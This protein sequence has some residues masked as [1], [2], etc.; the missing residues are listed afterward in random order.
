MTDDAHLV[1]KMMDA[2]S[3]PK[4]IRDVA[5]EFVNEILGVRLFKI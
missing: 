1:A 4:V 5:S 3:R 2:T